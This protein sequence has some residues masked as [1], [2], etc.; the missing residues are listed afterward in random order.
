VD[1]LSAAGSGLALELRLG[2]LVAL[3]TATSLAGDHTRADAYHDEV[4]A[5]TEPLGELRQR[6]WALAG[7]A[8]S[9]WQRG[10]AQEAE[11]STLACLHLIQ[12]STTIITWRAPP[13]I[14]AGRTGR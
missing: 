4:V 8:L 5:I 14:P 7:R 10:N 13:S 9:A 2:R 1:A 11:T 3:G 6:S 12:T